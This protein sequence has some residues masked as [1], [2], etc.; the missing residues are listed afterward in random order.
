[1][2]PTIRDT[3]GRGDARRTSQAGRRV[4]ITGGAGFV[5]VN[6]AAQLIKEGWAVTLLDNLIRP[7]TER[8]LKWIL[9]R[10]PTRVRFVKEDV[11]NVDAM[12]G[13]VRDQDAVLHLAAGMDDV[14]PRGTLNVLEAARQHNHDVPLVYTSTSK[15][16]G[17]RS[18]NSPCQE[19]QPLD[20]RGTY[21]S[22]KGAADQ[23]VRDYARNFDMNT[24]VLRLASVYGT[25][26]YG[27]EHEGWVAL[28]THSILR[29]RELTIRGDGTEVRDLLDVRDLSAVLATV[30]DKI[31]IARGEVY[32]VGGGNENKR[33]VLEVVHQIGE[34]S[35][36]KPRYDFG[37]S[38]DD[39]TKYY[40]S[41][42]EKA[43]RDLGW[44]PKI[45]FDRGLRDLVAW[46]ES[47]R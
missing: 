11:R 37:E 14:D 12:A 38:P 43:R 31:A 29:D 8:N 46:A 16:Y 18:E 26:E 2:D 41:D 24:V 45:D 4:L 40:V 47:V 25:H 13:H 39:D 3:D 27:N 44:E 5:G 22:S 33:S 17:P 15:V 32:N 19:T 21:A 28:F 9:T 30:I 35:G 36:R 1:M 7:G 10:Q 34:V 23:H 6:A 20:P 42:I